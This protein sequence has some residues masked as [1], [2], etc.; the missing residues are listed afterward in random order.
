MMLANRYRDEDPTGWWASEKLD[1]WRAFWD[2]DVL[3]T[4]TWQPIHA[5]AWMTASLPRGIALDGELWA[6]RGGFS[7]I[8]SLGQMDRPGDPR[9]RGVRFMVFDAPTTDAIP[10]EQRLAR[11]RELA[12]GRGVGFVE[13]RR[14]ASPNAL[15]R[16]FAEVQRKGGEGLVL[17]RPGSCYAFGRSSDWLKVKPASA[18]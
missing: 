16:W 18:D 15:W 17:R 1:G 9:W 7:V 2:G 8:Q 11:A 4:R 5:P 14:L 10:V 6:G 3:R 13:Q 12:R